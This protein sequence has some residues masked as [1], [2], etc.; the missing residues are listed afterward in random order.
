[1]RDLLKHAVTVLFG[2]GL[3]RITQLLTFL[4]LARLLTPEEFG[5]FGI[6][7]SGVVI[8]VPLATLGL[9]QAFA[10]QIGQGSLSPRQASTVT[11]LL[12]PPLALAAA[13]ILWTLYGQELPG[14]TAVSAAAILLVAVLGAMTVH[15]L[16]GISLG[17]GDIK[18]FATV[19][20]AAPMLLTIIVAV[21]AILGLISFQVAIWSYALSYV[22]V[23]PIAMA[24]GIVSPHL[25]LTSPAAMSAMVRYGIFFA[26]N[27]FI[28]TLN[29]RGGI[30]VL[31]Q[32]SGA[33]QS[34]QLFAAMR[35]NDV[36]IEGAI[37][38]GMVVFSRT[39]RANSAADSVSQSA[40]IASWVFITFLLASIGIAFL[41]GPI[42]FLLLGSEYASATTALQ[43]LCIGLGPAAASKIVY[44]AI[45][46][47]G[48]PLVGM[49][50]LLVS[51]L[52]NVG[53]AFL[54]G[55]HYGAAGVALAFSL[56]QIIVYVGYA[57][58]IGRR[59]KLPLREF[60]VPRR[61]DAAA[62]LRVA[63]RLLPRPKS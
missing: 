38:F 19:D 11:L 56:S 51:V 39:V 12:A 55:P 45:A 53:L 32:V 33:E 61:A 7:T 8:A 35:L 3:V 13:A 42:I 29:S 34:G 21:M 49:P 60:F 20:T 26:L 43:L 10:H 6:I 5:W 47:T 36:L 22:V 24:R 58:A 31:E 18:S 16:Q 1:M 25:A 9:R 14:I 30:I 41:A 28:S 52:V 2:R 54:L 40:R 63:T 50:V 37:A 15:M 23:L 62:L 17:L 48:Q 44:P 27:V 4:L 57:I 59:Y 46:G